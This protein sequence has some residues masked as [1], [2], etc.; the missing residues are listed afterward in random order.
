[1]KALLIL[2]VISMIGCAHA[3]IET[4]KTKDGE[5]C[6]ASYT[7][8]LKSLTEVKMT[9]CHAQ[10]EAGTSTVDPAAAV[11]MDIII[12]GLTTKVVAPVVPAVIP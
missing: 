11:L 1:M 10:G 3:T 6:K 12:K 4:T 9:A 2:L 5:T 8:G 7:S